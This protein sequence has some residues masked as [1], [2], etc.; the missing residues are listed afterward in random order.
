MDWF[1][2]DSTMVLYNVNILTEY[3]EESETEDSDTEMEEDSV[4]PTSG[5]TESNS[6]ARS[7]TESRSDPK[8]SSKGKIHLSQRQGPVERVLRVLQA[9]HRRSLQ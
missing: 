1:V 7:A 6:A 2:I 5:K 3:D 4:E 9:L 8:S